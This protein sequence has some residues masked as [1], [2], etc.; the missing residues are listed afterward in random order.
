MEVRRQP[1]TTTERQMNDDDDMVVDIEN[2]IVGRQP[3]KPKDCAE[4]GSCD[5]TTDDNDSSRSSD[6]DDGVIGNNQR[7][8]RRF[9]PASVLVLLLLLLLAAVVVS[10]ALGLTLGREQAVKQQPDVEDT[11]KEEGETLHDDNQDMGSEGT[12]PTTTT[13]TSTTFAPTTELEGAT[14]TTT[15]GT[16]TKAPIVE[17]GT[18]FPPDAVEWPML[19]GM[20]GLVAAE[21]LE[22]AYP[23]TYDIY[24]LSENSLVTMDYD[25][26][27]IR[28]FVSDATN[29]VVTTP[30]VG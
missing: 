23:N 15:G 5:H 6:H 13:T 26:Y 17:V 4:P 2:P 21:L 14:T 22:E 3:A 7:K 28:I 10:T 25:V 30:M 16:T 20:D 18:M 19:V 12:L 1:S 27:R 11:D 9:A 29:R 8:K 24:V